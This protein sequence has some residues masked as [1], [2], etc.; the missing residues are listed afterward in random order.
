MS[1]GNLKNKLSEKA[2]NINTS[3]A[4]PDVMPIAAIE[5]SPAA[6]NSEYIALRPNTLEIIRENLKHHSLTRASIDTIKSPSGGATVFTIPGIAGDEIEKE[7]CGIILDYT[8]PRAYWE[9]ND[10]V[11]GTPPTYYS[12]DSLVSHEGQPC[13]YC[14]FNEYGS[15]DGDSNAKACKESVEIYL[16][17]KDNIMPV[18]VRVPVS[19][20]AIFQR[21]MTRLVSHMIPACGVVTKITLEKAASKAGQPYAKFNFEAISELTPEETSG[22]R[23]FSQNI[24]EVLTADTERVIKTV[25]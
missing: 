1:I 12:L 9:T 22:I 14:P 17:R 25:S 24:M 10:P 19:S 23:L 3:H 15:K 6:V 20:K 7:L 5:L 2:Q 13:V 21:Y 11:E 16:L 8:T 18:I 4:N